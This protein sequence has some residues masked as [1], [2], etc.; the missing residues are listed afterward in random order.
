MLI[1]Q[2]FVIIKVNIDKDYLAVSCS[3]T[4]PFQYMSLS[5]YADI[6]KKCFRKKLS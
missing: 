4:K 2:F 3:G 5:A 6:D 1:Y